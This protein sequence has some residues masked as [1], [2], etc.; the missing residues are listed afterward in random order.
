MALPLLHFLELGVASWASR[1]PR[2]RP[3]VGTRTRGEALTWLLLRTIPHAEARA[4]EKLA[5]F[6]FDNH[7]FKHQVACVR[8]GR[9]V[10]RLDPAFPSYLFVLVVTDA[11]LRLQEM[12]EYFGLLSFVT[13]AGCSSVDLALKRL[14]GMALANDVLPVDNEEGARFKFGD[15]VQIV[16]NSHFALGLEGVYQ[17]RV[18]PGRV[19]IL[20]PWLGQL[21]PV[22][23]NESDIDVVQRRGRRSGRRHNRRHRHRFQTVVKDFA[24]LRAA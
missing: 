11:R 18:R 4:S 22:E 3:G 7:L 12:W 19:C 20:S 24:A 21:V 13:I 17:Y 2:E 5:R 6:D 15:K 14:L 10:T 16:T 9:V 23:V 1:F 8:R